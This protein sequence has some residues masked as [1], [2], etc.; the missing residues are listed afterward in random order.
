MVAAGSGQQAAGSRQQAAVRVAAAGQRA[1]RSVRCPTPTTTARPRPLQAPLSRRA[2]LG[3]PKRPK[4]STTSKVGQGQGQGPADDAKRYRIKRNP[5]QP[6][7]AHQHHH[8][9]SSSTSSRRPGTVTP[10]PGS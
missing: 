5:N 10:Q 9:S 6:P 3:N 2:A 1:R 8:A 7:P 4:V